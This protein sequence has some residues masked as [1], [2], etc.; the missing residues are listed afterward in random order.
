MYMLAACSKESTGNQGFVVRFW[1]NNTTAKEEKTSGHVE[2]TYNKQDK[3]YICLPVVRHGSFFNT[4]IELSAP[5]QVDK[6]ET[7]IGQP[8]LLRGDSLPTATKPS[9]RFKCAIHKIV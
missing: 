9:I 1:C 6:K 3:L 2:T 8:A 5:S 7:A 4:S